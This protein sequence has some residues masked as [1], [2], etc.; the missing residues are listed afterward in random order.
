MSF[1]EAHPVVLDVSGVEPAPCALPT[2]QLQQLL[3]AS[4]AH[5]CSSCV[6]GASAALPW[7]ELLRAAELP[8]LRSDVSLSL[9]AGWLLGY[10]CLYRHLPTAAGGG[11]VSALS[12]Q[13]LR[14]Y[15]VEVS[16]AAVLG[17]ALQQRRG[18]AEADLKRNSSSDNKALSAETAGQTVH[19]LDFTVPV[20]VVEGMDGPCAEAFLRALRRQLGQARAVFGA[21][22]GCRLVAEDFVSLSVM[23]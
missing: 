5:C 4:F 11:L 20:A 22:A 3:R 6:A 17:H 8:Q 1:A 15:S 18:H 21:G 14:K 23:L 12:A 7:L 19:V 9:T 2:G 16:A 13:P 10:P